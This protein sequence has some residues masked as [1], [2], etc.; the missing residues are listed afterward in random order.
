MKLCPAC[1]QEFQ[2]E[3]WTCHGCGWQAEEREG[4]PVLGKGGDPTEGGF[5]PDQHA[6]LARQ[7]DKHFWFR[8][9]NRLILSALRARFANCASM[10]EIGCG[11]GYVLSGMQRLFPKAE[12]AG[13]ELFVEGLAFARQRLGTEVQLLQM[14]ARSLPYKEEFDVVGAFDV[15]EHIE[16][17]RQVLAEMY[18]ATKPGGG[19]LLTVPQHPWLWSRLDEISHHV[20]RYTRKELQEK[21]ESAGF[22]LEYCCSFVS[23]LLPLMILS[24]KLRRPR[25]REEEERREFGLWPPLSW[26]LERTLD[27]ELGLLRLGIKLPVGGSVLLAARKPA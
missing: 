2:N 9:R 21:V 23:L 4:F 11:T 6:G 3:R 17:D 24:R 8:A 13:S 5:D 1:S 22:S 26:A 18:R 7:E 15:L 14:D 16:D 19:I 25:P 27:F 12:L 20:R 10:L